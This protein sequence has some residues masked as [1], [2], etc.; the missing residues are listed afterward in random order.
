MQIRPIRPALL[1]QRRSGGEQAVLIAVCRIHIEVERRSEIAEL[2]RRIVCARAS[3]SPRIIG[4]GAR[5]GG[6]TCSC[7]GCRRADCTTHG[8]ADLCDFRWRDIEPRD[9]AL[10]GT[11]PR[12]VEGRTHGST[13]PVAIASAWNRRGCI[14]PAGLEGIHPSGRTDFRHIGFDEV[15]CIRAFARE[16]LVNQTVAIVIDPVAIFRAA[17]GKRRAIGAYC[18]ARGRRS[19][20]TDVGTRRSACAIAWGRRRIVARAGLPEVWDVFIEQ[21]VAI[22]IE[23]VARFVVARAAACT[24]ARGESADPRPARACE[25]HARRAFGA[26]CRWAHA[27]DLH[28]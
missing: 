20:R 6:L 2:V 10:H 26:R 13:R 5:L 12:F 16:H 7:V 19:A 28:G 3:C 23:S 24:Y 25:G 18:I 21:T 8:N 22:V 15:C 27:A 17:A 4:P 1:Q 9:L 11:R 14:R